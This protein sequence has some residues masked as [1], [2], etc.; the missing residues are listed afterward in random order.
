VCVC[1]CV[2]VCMC[3]SLTGRAAVPGASSCLPVGS[4]MLCT[5]LLRPDSTQ[6]FLPECLITKLP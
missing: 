4:G 1:V 2:C 5:P 3:G 6:V